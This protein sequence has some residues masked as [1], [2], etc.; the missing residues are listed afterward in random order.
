M[1]SMGE[2]RTGGMVGDPC[3]LSLKA[4]VPRRGNGHLQTLQNDQSRKVLGKDLSW[5]VAKGLLSVTVF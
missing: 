5:Q 4:K 3:R 1:P 2:G